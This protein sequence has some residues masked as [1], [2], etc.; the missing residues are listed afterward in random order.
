[1]NAGLL[2]HKVQVK[3]LLKRL[4]CEHR[5]AVLPQ[6]VLPSFALHP[7]GVLPL[8]RGSLKGKVRSC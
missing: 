2:Q 1:M 3:D 5:E 6:V 7:H 8:E 4:E